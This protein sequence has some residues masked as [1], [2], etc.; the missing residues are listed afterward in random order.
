M[1]WVWQR[2]RGR[3]EGEGARGGGCTDTDLVLLLGL[4]VAV[5]PLHHGE[6]S[7]G[8][9]ELERRVERQV[10]N[11][12]RNILLRRVNEA[13]VGMRSRDSWDAM[14]YVKTMRLW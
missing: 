12:V 5:E 4:E 8:E 3:G 14:C 11:V 1:S 7:L 2:A 13:V 9:A 10:R 6:G